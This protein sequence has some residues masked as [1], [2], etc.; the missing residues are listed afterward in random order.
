MPSAIYLMKK[1]K[2]VALPEASSRPDAVEASR[3]PVRVKSC[4]YPAFPLVLLWNLLDVQ[5][6]PRLSVE[7]Q[8]CNPAFRKLSQEDHVRF[9]KRE[10]HLKNLKG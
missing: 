5:K 9:S 10:T 4:A 8:A 7:T 3:V 2:P 6:W 1:R